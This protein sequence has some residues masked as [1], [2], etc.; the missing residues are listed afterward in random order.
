M[1]MLARARRIAALLAAV[2]LAAPAQ[3]WEKKDYTQWSASDCRQVLE[4]SPWG[5]KFTLAEERREA[6]T[7]NPTRGAGLESSVRL[8]YIAQLRS[9]LPIRQAVVRQL[10]LENKY[11]RMSE[12][13][14]RDL[15]RRAAIYLGMN[16]DKEIVIQVILRC[17]VEI[18]QRQLVDFWLPM[19]EKSIANQV[20]LINARGQRIAPAKYLPPTQGNPVLEFVFPRS[21]PGG[22]WIDPDDREFLL[23]MPGYNLSTRTAESRILFT[24][25]LQN[26]RYQGQLSF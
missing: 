17:N 12:E 4:N 5:Q 19:T 9:A 21:G 6:F 13:E 11:E 23:E 7:P 25:K 15:D 26:L 10:Q 16:F 3:V 8:E 20:Y 14:K 2:V 18:H 22:E 24:F 1:S